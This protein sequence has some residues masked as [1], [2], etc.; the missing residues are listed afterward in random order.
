MQ[1]IDRKRV[2]SGSRCQRKVVRQHILFV[3]PPGLL[4]FFYYLLLQ[5]IFFFEVLFLFFFFTM[6]VPLLNAQ[7]Y[8]GRN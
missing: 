4:Q 1:S 3:P 8:P 5:H 6:R 7:R 2:P